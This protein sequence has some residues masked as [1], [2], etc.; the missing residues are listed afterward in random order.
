MTLVYFSFKALMKDTVIITCTL[1]FPK[2]YIM[3]IL[4][5]THI[6]TMSH[7]MKRTRLHKISQIIERAQ[8]S[9]QSYTNTWGKCQSINVTCTCTISIAIMGILLQ[10]CPLGVTLYF[11]WWLCKYNYYNMPEFFSMNPCF[12][13]VWSHIEQAFSKNAG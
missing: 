5:Q 3:W 6:Y 4:L 1:V 10:S 8:S 13:E 11:R 9:I 7:E 12:M 2:H